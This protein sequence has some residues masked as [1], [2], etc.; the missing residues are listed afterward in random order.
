MIR[1]TEADLER[2][3]DFSFDMSRVYT[4]AI[5]EADVTKQTAGVA[6]RSQVYEVQVSQVSVGV[7]GSHGHH[8]FTDAMYELQRG[9]Y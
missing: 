8:Q 1:W 9:L 6:G 4:G 3:P 5:L 2:L 7:I